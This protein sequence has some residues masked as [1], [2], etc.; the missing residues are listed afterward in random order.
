MSPKRTFT[1][2]SAHC[3]VAG[4]TTSSRAGA[5]HLI[6]GST[7]RVVTHVADQTET[8]RKAI[9]PDEQK[10]PDRRVSPTLGANTLAANRVFTEN[11]NPDAVVM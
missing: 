5:G 3:C 2:T 9:A 8:F 1:S 6:G 10:L 7:A 11:L 4:G